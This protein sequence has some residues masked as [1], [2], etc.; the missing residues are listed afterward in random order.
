[1]ANMSLLLGRHLIFSKTAAQHLEHLR[2][3]F[4][5]LRQ[6]KLKLKPKK[7]HFYQKEVAFLG[8]VVNEEGV[9]TDPSKVQKAIDCPA[10][11]DV[12]EVK[13]IMGLFSYIGDSS[14]FQ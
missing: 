1:M 3:V 2:T 12:H 10:P 13:S 8:H 7:C 4:L 9:S 6:A 11:Q 14:A 5:R